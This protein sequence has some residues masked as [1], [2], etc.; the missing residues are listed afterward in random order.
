MEHPANLAADWAGVPD[1]TFQ[2]AERFLTPSNIASVS[3]RGRKVNQVLVGVAD[4]G[5]DCTGV[6][7][8]PA[9]ATA[10]LRA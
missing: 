2:Q 9:D 8:V 7:V 1:G 10:A 3:Q 5:A 6:A 4:T